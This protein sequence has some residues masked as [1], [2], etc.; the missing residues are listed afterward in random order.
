MNNIVV[1]AIQQE[2]LHVRRQIEKAIAGISDEAFFRT[3]Q[4]PLN[5]IA[6][7]I[8]HMAG[9]LKSRWTDFLTTDGEKPD[10][11]RDGEFENAPT[12]TR[13]T[14]LDRWQIGW[15]ILDATLASLSDQQLGETVTIR[16]E[17]YTVHGAM[18]RALSHAAYHAGQ[19]LYLVRWT[20]PDAPWQTIPKK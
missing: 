15:G 5:S 13:E 16:G 20:T 12:D 2:F 17:A 9:N 18:L 7:I 4:E 6:I 10:R 19:I 3:P 8:K 1:A 14:I 11:N